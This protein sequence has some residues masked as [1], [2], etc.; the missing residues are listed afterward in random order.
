MNYDSGLH[1]RG[2]QLPSPKANLMGRCTVTDY[3]AN[4]RAMLILLPWLQD[5]K[6][7]LVLEK[8]LQVFFPHSAGSYA[9]CTSL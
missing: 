3:Y 7:F 2:G 5:L 9:D 1:L 6:A 8:L 4:N